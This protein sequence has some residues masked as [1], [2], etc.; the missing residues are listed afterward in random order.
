MIESGMKKNFAFF[1]IALLCFDFAGG[2]VREKNSVSR[3][4]STENTAQKVIVSRTANEVPNPTVS[5]TATNSNVVTRTPRTVSDYLGTVAARSSTQNV[6]NRSKS[7]ST[8]N[9]IKNRTSVSTAAQTISRSG[10][11][12]ISSTQTGAAYEQCKSAFFT[13]MDQ[14]CVLKNDT[15]RRCSCSDRVYEFEELQAALGEAEDELKT[16]VEN[17]DAVG[18]TAEQAIAMKTSTEGE[19]ALSEDSSGSKALLDAI[20]DSIRG[21]SGNGTNLSGKFS[22]LNSINLSF[23]TANAFGMTDSGQVIAS[24]NGEN[25]YSAIY[26]QCRIAVQEDC[27]DSSLQRAVTAYLMAIEQDCNTVES[28]I[29]DN[30]KKL[31]KSI[32]EG[33]ALLN[34]ARVENRQNLNSD[35][36]STCLANVED[37]VLSEEVCGKDYKK[38]LDNG[39]F[40]DI[41]TGEPIAGVTKFYELEN[42]L[43]FETDEDLAN[44]QL[45][46]ITE[47]RAFVQNFEN[48]VKLFAEPA[49]N[50]CVEDA[51]AV[52]ADYLDKALLDIFYAQKSKV[53][54]IKNECFSFIDSC[55]TDTEKALDETIGEL[56][57]DV[58]NSLQPDKISLT[59]Q[60]CRDY[61]ESCDNMFDGNI[62]EQYVQSIQT[63]D[64]ESACR[65]VAKQCF[66]K[67]G[68]QGYQN[69]YYPFSGLFSTGEALDWFTL[70]SY[71]YNSDG[72]QIVEYKSEC[73]KQLQKIDSC[74]DP[75]MMVKVF[76]GIDKNY[77]SESGQYSYGMHNESGD[78][79]K[80][81]IRNQGV[82]SEIHTQILDSL[83]RQ[84]ESVMGKFIE[85]RY[86]KSNSYNPDNL[87][88]T[89]FLGYGITHDSIYKHLALSYGVS[90]SENVC[91]ANYSYSVDTDSWGI[92]SC[93]E[94]GARRSKN[95]VT[96]K[97]LPI[98]PVRAEKN[99]AA[100]DPE[101]DSVRATFNPGGQK[102]PYENWCTQELTSS[103]NQ[104]C[105][106]NATG[107]TADGLCIFNPS[108]ESTTYETQVQIIPHGNM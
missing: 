91:P 9:Q 105:P 60:I 39:E 88:Q 57:A 65:T 71:T 98:I 50:K 90:H 3:S 64:T 29:K 38:C 8:T 56:D 45:S 7:T 61:V 67:Y 13:C 87:C 72:E 17:L 58:S 97:C 19:D 73:A 62:L 96:T 84:C 107:L 75:E 21:D 26:S 23:D 4:T 43:T 79:E 54:E 40:I 28:A 81:S 5:R 1:L 77:D 85:L 32:S 59:S 83:T 41:S 24:Y 99:D 52:W 37:A 76:G 42:I 106:L 46:K 35:D 11:T 82:A 55:Y 34:L 15:Y 103:L 74:S 94:N 14:F 12:G 33:G 93:W 69:F 25:L 44:Q 30:Q 31:S 101:T 6:V 51:D 78:W 53:T 18:L 102:P 92:C 108:S 66:D 48:R 100:C 86:I 95:G 10:T 80:N 27:D 47:N 89:A 104:I 70:Q 49:L 16:F 20:M 2:A 68:G 22:G 36:I 63:E